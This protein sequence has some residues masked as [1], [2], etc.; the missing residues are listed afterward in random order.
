[1]ALIGKYVIRR[2]HFV[3]KKWLTPEE[4]HEI[5]ICLTTTLNAYLNSIGKNN[6]IWFSLS[7]LIGGEN[8]FWP[9][10]IKHVYNV[11]VAHN[12]NTAFSNAAKDMGWVLLKI[13]HDDTRNFRIEHRYRKGKN[14]RVYTWID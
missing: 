9:N 14:V 11:Y 1:M 5:N 10:P 13:L 2:P 3:V 12:E 6:N 4:I 7:D 8:K